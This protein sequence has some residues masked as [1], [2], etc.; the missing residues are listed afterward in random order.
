[1]FRNDFGLYLGTPKTQDMIVNQEPLIERVLS[2]EEQKSLT[3][4]DVIK[5][6]KE[7]NR[8]FVSGT[9]TLRD[10]SKQIRDCIN[11]Q[12]PKA[13]ILSCIDSRVPVEDIFDKGIGDLFV[14]RVAGNIVNE[15]ILGSMEFSC[16]VAGAKLV[17]VIGHEYCGAVKGAID[18]VELGNLTSLLAKLKPAIAACGHY[19]GEKT[20]YDPKFLDL[21]IREN[22]RVTVEAIRRQSPILR[23]MEVNGEIKIAGAYYEMDTGTVEFYE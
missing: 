23:E 14:A 4:D 16:K 12:F 22:V 7:G 19:H 21:V 9:L 3:P 20:S 13:I 2:A 5:S 6:L 17:L 18:N 10:H 11:G 15:D 1:L 8:R